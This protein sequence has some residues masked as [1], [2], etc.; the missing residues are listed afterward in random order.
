MRPSIRHLGTL[1]LLLGAVF[2]G[3]HADEGMWTFDNLPV[4]QMKSKYG[5]APDQAWLDHIRLS[6]LRFPGGSGSFISP[7]GLVLTNHHV[8]HDYIL[9]VSDKDHDYIRDGFVARGR[10]LEI[11]VPGLVLKCLVSSENITPRVE[12]AVSGGQSYREAVASVL[13]EE[14]SRTSFSCE[15]VS[16]YQGGEDWIYRYKV[17]TDVRLV[18]APEY[19]ISA[20]GKDWDNFSYPRHDLDFSLWRVY[21]NGEP[22]HPAHHLQWSS[23]GVAYGDMTFVVGHPGLTSRL[24]TLAQI[25]FR[26]DV[27]NPLMVRSLDRQRKAL[28]VFSAQNIER[29]RLASAEIM[30]TENSFKVYEGELLMLRD[31]DALAKVQKSEEL[32]RAAVLKDPKLNAL[33]GLSWSHIDG[34]LEKRKALAKEEQLFLGR[35]RSLVRGPLEWALWALSAPDD[36]LMKGSSG[37][38]IQNREMEIGVLGTGMREALEELGPKHPLVKAILEGGLPEDVAR[39]TLTDT[40]LLDP[41]S[42]KALLEGG[43]KAIQ[44]SRDPLLQLARKVQPFLQKTRQEMQRLASAAAEENLRIAKARFAI[45]GR[46]VYPDATFTLRFSYGALATYPENGTLAQPFT[47]FGGLFDRADAWGPTAEN[48]SWALPPRWIQRRAA[49]NP[50]TPYNFITSNDIIGGNSGSP[51][52]DQK[53][54]LV[55]LAFDGNLESHLGRFTYNPVNNRCLCVDTRA[56]VE[57]LA[58]VY[59]AEA[60]VQEIRH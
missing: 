50:S 52:L 44:E 13:A 42:R 54:E 7:D 35:W 47:T 31:K 3:L 22:Y 10:A 15:P 59:D 5:F 51:V 49:L 24:E 56:I 37:L 60:L 21:E 14:A 45:Y 41:V 46:S 6:A 38:E 33:A 28:R 58:K 40:A 43:T 36:V 12:K 20:F 39:K 30:S 25:Q 32:L 18:M 53:G 16:L 1:A 17:F 4:E 19:E 27:Q 29:A 8:G 55:G 48:G 34:I 57:A 2:P 23:K 11:P 9:Q 26:R